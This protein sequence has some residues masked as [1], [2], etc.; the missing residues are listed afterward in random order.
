LAFLAAGQ[1]PGRPDVEQ[2]HLAAEVGKRARLA[3][4]IGEPDLGRGG[5]LFAQH[6][7]LRRAGGGR[8]RQ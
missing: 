2:H 6:E 4:A 3:D 1:A 8:R 7:I 5:R